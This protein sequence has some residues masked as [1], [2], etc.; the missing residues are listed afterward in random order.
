M[1]L[2]A[3]DS[4]T[5]QAFDSEE[6][7][8]P[9]RKI[10]IKHAEVLGGGFRDFTGEKSD[11]G[12]M[13]ICISVPSDLISTFTNEGIKVSFWSPEDEDEDG[14]EQPGLVT[15]KLNFDYYKQPKIYVKVGNDG[16]LVEYLKDD[17]P[18]LRSS[19]F[20]DANF[21]VKVVHGEFRKKPYTSLYIDTA[22]FTIKQDHLSSYEQ[23]MLNEFGGR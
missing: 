3:N 16:E 8:R 12:V 23:D 11:R 18:G 5:A 14:I 15:L 7:G 9:V 13:S 20:S 10:S 6:N 2:R 17:M 4:M 1:A 21:I 19:I 22:W